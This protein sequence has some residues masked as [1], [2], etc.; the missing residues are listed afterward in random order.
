MLKN[1]YRTTFELDFSADQMFYFA[2]LQN[3]LHQMLRFKNFAFIRKT[4]KLYAIKVHQVF[5]V[6]Q[7][8]EL[9]KNT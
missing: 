9:C 8:L 7:H 3:I 1:I 5:A 4:V 2:I 6:L